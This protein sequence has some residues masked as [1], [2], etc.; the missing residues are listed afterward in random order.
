MTVK[1]QC[2]C[3]F[4]FLFAPLSAQTERPA[5]AELEQLFAG[6]DRP[7]APGLA[8]SVR[9]R[10]EVVFERAYGLAD[11]STARKITTNTAFATGEMSATFTAYALLNLAEQGAVSLEDSVSKYLPELKTRDNGITLRHLLTRSE[12][13]WD[14]PAAMAVVG[15]SGGLVRTQR[16]LSTLA[17]EPRPWSSP[18]T[19]FTNSDTGLWLAA[20]VVSR[21]SGDDFSTYCAKHIFQPLG[22]KDTYFLAPG[23]LPTPGTAKAY[24][25]EGEKFQPANPGIHAP[26]PLGVYTSVTDLSRWEEYLANASNDETTNALDKLDEIVQ[27]EDGH[28]HHTQ[29]G[30]LTYGQLY[31]HSERGLFKY[32]RYGRRL[33]FASSLFRFPEQEFSVV[34]LSNNGLGYNGYLGMRLAYLF[35][36]DDFLRPATI[37]FAELTPQ[38]V[39]PS[40]KAN[41]AGWYWHDKAMLVREVRLR[42]DSLLF[43]SWGSEME[44]FPLSNTRFQLNGGGDDLMYVEFPGGANGSQMLFTSGGSDLEAFT[45]YTPMDPAAINQEEYV[46][47]YLATSLGV[48]YTLRVNSTNELILANP[49]LGE[50]N[51]T[52]FMPDRFYGNRS[53]W[54]NLE[55]DRNME[56]KVNGFCLRIDGL[57]VPFAKITLMKEEL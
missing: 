29:A 55:F 32:Y 54:W 47:T 12:G 37:S 51:L 2:L 5:D 33:G 7:D 20:E 21:V 8:V 43:V 22:M 9:Y 35:L 14:Y 41:Y 48:T 23:Q 19:A 34:V 36:E 25:A 15:G 39:T 26:G 49:Q 30:E 16:L 45:R 24:S 10:G 18:G 31:R 44:M 52:G 50:I 56:G 11:L 27:L 46:G 4:L 38:P 17:A 40:E 28:E 1:Y 42:N 6:F 3:L 13:L 57:R 53:P